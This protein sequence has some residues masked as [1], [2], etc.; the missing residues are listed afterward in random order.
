MK[1][2]RKQLEVEVEHAQITVML[3]LSFERRVQSGPP[4]FLHGPV[5]RVL[6]GCTC[7][8][9]FPLHEK[10]LKNYISFHRILFS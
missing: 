3:L 8:V 9:C 1:E 10:R 4:E 5:H 2:R 7:K 6:T